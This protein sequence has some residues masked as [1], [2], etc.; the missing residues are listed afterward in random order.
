MQ[1][2]EL[3]P[4]VKSLEACPKSGVHNPFR[5]VDRYLM[6]GSVSD[7]ISRALRA[8]EIADFFTRLVMRTSPKSYKQAAAEVSIWCVW[9]CRRPVRCTGVRVCRRRVRCSGLRGRYGSVHSSDRRAS[10]LCR[11]P[12]CA[13]RPARRRARHLHG[14]SPPALSPPPAPFV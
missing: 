1:A 11:A 4:F 12:S 2:E 13:P 10:W 9:V 14:S 6:L 8:P 5:N 7:K 3:S